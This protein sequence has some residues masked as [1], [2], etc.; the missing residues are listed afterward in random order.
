M[1]YA[2]RDQVVIPREHKRPDN[3]P[4]IG[5]RP[6]EQWLE[7]RIGKF[8]ME[9]A[10]KTSLEM[11]VPLPIYG[12]GAFMYKGAIHPAVAD[13][14]RQQRGNASRF[15]GDP[16]SL[17]NAIGQ[18]GLSMAMLPF[19]GFSS[20][21][22]LINE[23]TVNGKLQP[24]LAFNKVGVTGVANRAS[25]LWY[26][27]NVPVV[28]ATS[29]AFSSNGTDH[30]RTTTGALGPQYN[31]AGGDTLH[32]IGAEGNASVVSQGLL[33]YDR[34]WGGEPAATTTGVQNATMTA[35]RYAGTGSGGTSIGNF[36]WVENRIA[37]TAAGTLTLNY[38]DDA[39]NAA[40]N[41]AAVTVAT[42]TVKVNPFA[43]LIGIPLNAGDAGVSDIV[44]INLSNSLTTTP[45]ICVVLAHPLMYI[46]GL[47]VANSGYIRDGINSAFNFQRIYDN[48][49]LALLEPI[50]PAT[51]ATTYTGFLTLCSG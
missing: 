48:A 9:Q 7:D 27:G 38:V 50:K 22:D 19:M 8:C 45:S 15:W 12:T 33:L 26:E 42:G 31:A 37:M 47:A 30:T 41:A 23:A 49:C 11:N 4:W 29:A 5:G 13:N 36:V 40:E 51:T 24:L 18:V 35:V 3:A 39:G 10:Y 21:S 28:G 2:K 20:L 32:L 43:G 25:T 14:S 1:I 6:N 16:K 17:L 34:I 46:P 44:S